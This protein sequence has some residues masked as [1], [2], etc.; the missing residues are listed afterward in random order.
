MGRCF[1][2]SILSARFSYSRWE[3]IFAKRP[4]T[5]APTA[6]SC[7]LRHLRL[8]HWRLGLRAWHSWTCGSEA[9]DIAWNFKSQFSTNSSKIFVR[10]D[11]YQEYNCPIHVHAVSKLY[12]HWPTICFAIPSLI[13]AIWTD[14]PWLNEDIQKAIPSQSPAAKNQSFTLMPNVLCVVPSGQI[15]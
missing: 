10:L 3:V 12:H 4:P 8:N 7:T 9:S 1:F 6:L 14:N 11:Y 15:R 2:R 13:N 5:N